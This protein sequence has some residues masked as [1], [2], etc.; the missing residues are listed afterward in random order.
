MTP[1]SFVK[2]VGISDDVE[3]DDSF[4]LAYAFFIELDKKPDIV[5]Q[6]MFF[7]EWKKSFFLLKR[8]ITIEDVKLRVVFAEGEEEAQ[9]NFYKEL[10][11][12]VNKRVFE[13]NEDILRKKQREE[14]QKKNQQAT[15][16][17]L[18]NRIKLL[19]QAQEA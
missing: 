16:E 13:Y 12:A 1:G 14:E 11:E 3:K 2:Y 9:L 15:I 19:S 7:D 17:Q 10:I 5:W 18:R 8:Q 6:Q 4:P